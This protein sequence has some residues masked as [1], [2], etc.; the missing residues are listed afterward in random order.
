MPRTQ[1]RYELGRFNLISNLFTPEVEGK[2][3]FLRKGLTSGQAEESRGS[4]W[5]FLDVTSI[6]VEDVEYL[7]GY[8]VK[9]DRREERKVVDSQ[10]RHI[11]VKVLENAV[12]AA[13]GFV[14]HPPSS[15]IAFHPMPPDIP[16]R[17]FIE[18]FVALFELGHPSS[19]ISAEI[20]LIHEDHKVLDAIRRFEAISRVFVYLH[21]SNPSNREQWRDFDE[22]LRALRVTKY[23]E[24]YVAPVQPGTSGLKIAGDP[25]I[26]KKVVMAQDGYGEAGVTGIDDG[27]PR[28]VT[29]KAN[30]VT[31]SVPSD[32]TASPETIVRSIHTTIQRLLERF[33]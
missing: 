30:P 20:Q 15:I 27:R 4:Y 18:R 7:H 17:T 14:I 3:E 25:D 23:R 31:A 2:F 24:E 10:R 13:A 32:A 5:S 28:T 11:D 29:T 33:K 9:Y 8:L 26:E 1:V 16:R 6:P 22:R 12:Q 21:P 19:F